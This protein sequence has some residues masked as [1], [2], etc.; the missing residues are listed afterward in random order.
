MPLKWKRA[1]TGN[2]A[3]SILWH[4]LHYSPI[5][6]NSLQTG[7]GEHINKEVK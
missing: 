3:R 5:V 6:F 4:P 2:E 7:G 1:N